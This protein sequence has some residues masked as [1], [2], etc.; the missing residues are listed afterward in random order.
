M[1]NKTIIKDVK[2]SDIDIKTILDS[3]KIINH[4]CPSDFDINDYGKPDCRCCASCWE[5]ALK[6]KLREEDT[7]N[8]K[9]D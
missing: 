7:T 5:V 1:A 4:H 8:A 2:I 6:L 3:V 9:T